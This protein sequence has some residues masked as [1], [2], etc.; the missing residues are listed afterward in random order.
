M[1]CVTLT[2]LAI[3]AVSLGITGCAPK[4]I[5]QETLK[6]GSESDENSL[7][8]IIITEEPMTLEEIDAL[9][10]GSAN[11]SH[12]LDDCDDNKA[13]SPGDIATIVNLGKEAWTFIEDR[14]PV[15][16]YALTSANA[17]PR[18]ARC[19]LDLEAWSRPRA[20]QFRVVYKN[21]Y[22]FEIVEFA[23]RLVFTP[24]GSFRGKGRYLSHVTVLP[25]EIDVPWFFK[26]NAATTVKNV[27]NLGT[28]DN[29]LAGIELLVEWQVETVLQHKQQSMSFGIYGDGT[30]E[31]LR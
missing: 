29:P 13:I 28:A 31:V 11:K 12:L 21:L 26:L 19:W 6:G 3:F 22:G 9:N 4:T 14:K 17:L 25:A 30:Y 16:K 10:Q 7:S 23:F 18:G 27:F 8:E 20:R 24:G 2:L 5:H 1:K 15:V